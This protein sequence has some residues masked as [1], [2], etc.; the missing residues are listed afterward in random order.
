[1]TMNKDMEN[2]PITSPPS[3]HNWLQLID[4]LN[5]DTAQLEEVADQL[6]EA[7]AQIKATFNVISQL[8]RVAQEARQAN[9]RDQ[10]ER[11]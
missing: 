10:R 1:M 11:R 2:D 5:D 4:V 6:K 9:Q 7:I 3:P 8:I